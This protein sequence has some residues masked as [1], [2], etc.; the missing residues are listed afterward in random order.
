MSGVRIIPRLDIK[1]LN[2]VKGIRL[3]GLRILGEPATFARRYYADGAD[4]LLFM[5]VYASLLGRDQLLDLVRATT[6]EVFIPLTVGGGI[7]SVG[8]IVD[9]LRAGADKVAINTAAVLRPTLISEA[10]QR[11]GSQC[12]VI[13]IEAKQRAPGRW[14]ALTDNG[15]EPTGL[16][17]LEWACRAEALGAGEILLTSVDKEGTRKGYDLEL[18]S[19]VRRRVRVPVI[20]SGGAGSSR[21]LVAAVSVADVDA[22]SLGWVLHHG[23]STIPLLKSDLSRAGIGVR[24]TSEVAS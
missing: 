23:L 1:G 2:L 4:E 7:R 6:T 11:F 24:V 10:A 18:L 13:S 8:D 21:D 20:A 16:D 17:V 5:D 15:R 14:E 22:V 3:E 19:E 9:V 12:V